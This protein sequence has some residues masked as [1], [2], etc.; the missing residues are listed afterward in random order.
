MSRKVAR[1]VACQLVFEYLFNKKE[2][3]QTKEQL[4]DENKF[5][6]ADKEFVDFLANG[7]FENFDVLIAKIKENIKDFSF[8]QVVKMDLAILLVAT[9]EITN[10]NL[11]HAVII[12][13]AL[14]IAKKFSTEKSPSFING[15]LASISRGENGN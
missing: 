7:V 3:E 2:N 11:D 5:I 6:K 9:F 8:S 10:S 12:N 14:N 1:E 4:F 15:V 13:E